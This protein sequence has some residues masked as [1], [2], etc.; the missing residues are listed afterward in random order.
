MTAEL[1]PFT[2]TSLED[3]ANVAVS[4][5]GV[6]I[7]SQLRKVLENPLRDAGESAGD[8]V[9]ETD[10]PVAFQAA[11]KRAYYLG[12]ERFLATIPGMLVKISN[13][14]P[15][16]LLPLIEQ[17]VS[18]RFD[19]KLVVANTAVPV[20]QKLFNLLGV[21]GKGPASYAKIRFAVFRWGRFLRFCSHGR[22]PGFVSDLL[23]IPS[24][25]CRALSRRPDVELW[26]ELRH[27][28][29]N[30][31]WR[32]YL[33]LNT[34]VVAS[35]TADEL[36]WVLGEKIRH[37]SVLF[38]VLRNDCQE[39]L[40]Y[41]AVKESSSVSG[42]W[43]VVDWI[44]IGNDK[45]ILASLMFGI[46]GALMKRRKDV[47]LLESIGFPDQADDVVR[48]YLTWTRKTK[49]NCFLYKA[50]DKRVKAA[51]ETDAGWFFGPMDGDRCL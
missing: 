9:Y 46:K 33:L 19:R 16:N 47:F 48:R 20:T 34:G 29:I 2:E 23:D 32:R 50:F 7:V 3:A 6:G 18:D 26:Q 30:D 45:K 31:F 10:N 51:I 1:R 28:D 25:V 41:V 24:L 21:C 40:G 49:N 35:R 13:A 38:G 39:V 44:A 43:M 36:E 15:A 27:D 14:S 22:L 11:I 17:T 12:S 42:R 37:G 5:F 4:G 8:I